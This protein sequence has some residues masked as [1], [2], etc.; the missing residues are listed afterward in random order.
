[1][2]CISPE[3]FSQDNPLS[4]PSQERTGHTKPNTTVKPRHE[5]QNAVQLISM[6]DTKQSKP[7][8][9]LV[10]FSSGDV[11][12]LCKRDIKEA[13]IISQ[14]QINLTKQKAKKKII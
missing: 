9:H 4:A 12:I 6:T 1:M 10:Y 7:C 8:T 2:Q 13:L 14:I 5:K 11:V 3:Q